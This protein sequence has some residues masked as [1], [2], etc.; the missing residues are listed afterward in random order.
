MRLLVSHDFFSPFFPFLRDFFVVGFCLSMASV[1]WKQ[2]H[3]TNASFH[4]ENPVLGKFAELPTK[5]Q[6][7][8]KT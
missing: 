6:K 7:S 1:R 4:K 8:E 2:M 5:P 3:N